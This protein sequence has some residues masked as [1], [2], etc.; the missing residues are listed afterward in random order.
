[1][2]KQVINIGTSPNDNTGDP[3][4]QALS[5]ANENFTELYNKV[6]I[7][8]TFVN[9]PTNIDVGFI[10]FCTDRQTIEGTIN[11]IPIFYKGSGIWVDALGRV[12]S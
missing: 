12:V 4:R 11:G 7:N 10:Y 8:G 3:L 1:M 6:F 9:K 2:A 5:K